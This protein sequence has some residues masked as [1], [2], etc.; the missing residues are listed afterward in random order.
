MGLGM[1]IVV[2]T[3][4]V[5]GVLWV[6][7]SAHPKLKAIASD[8]ISG[9]ITGFLLLAF[10]Y[11]IITTISPDL[12]IFHYNPISTTPTPP[13]P[14][15]KIFSPGVYLYTTADCA[16]ET[17]PKDPSKEPTYTRYTK[18]ETNLKEMKYK[19]KSGKIVQGASSYIMF[20]HELPNFLGGCEQI[21]PNNQVCL[22]VT[23]P[24]KPTAEASS[25]S[26][27]QFYTGGM[28]DGVKF[29]RKPYFNEAGGW[30]RIN[31]EEFALG[32]ITFDG[33]GGDCTVPE[34]EQDCIKWEPTGQC[35][36]DSRRCPKVTMENINSIETNGDYIVLFFYVGGHSSAS[37][38]NPYKWSNCQIFPTP[39]DL[40]LI[41]PKEMKWDYIRKYGDIPNRVA[42]FP[43]V[44]SPL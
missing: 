7:S 28:G 19:L 31:A 3:L 16:E 18:S 25:M 34:E 14:P 27:Y 11:L 8:R 29:Y 38:P 32:D 1:L 20:F 33:D 24:A 21:D 26:I 13:R 40:N 9:A 44:S 17:T 2:A 30:V 37:G 15:T 23:S 22:N 6:L 5:G 36:K 42:I 43:I 12:G 35:A 41:G 4:A 39:E 10:T